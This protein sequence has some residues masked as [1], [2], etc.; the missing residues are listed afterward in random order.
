MS[1]IKPVRS[2]VIANIAE[3][4]R[5]TMIKGFSQSEFIAWDEASVSL[6]DMSLFWY[7]DDKVVLLPVQ[8][9]KLFLSDLND[10]LG[11]K[12]V[13][14][15]WPKKMSY[16]VC[17]DILNDKEL[18]QFLIKI[19][20][21][22]D[23]PEIVTW[24]ATKPFYSL[25][26]NLTQTGARFITPEIPKQTDYWTTLYFESKAGFREFVTKET[27]L[28]NIPEGFICGDKDIALD[29]IAYFSKNNRGFVLKANY[30][31]AGF[32]TMCY[33][34]DAIN[35][36]FEMLRKEIAY[37]MSFDNFWN[38]PPVIIEEH[39]TGVNDS[40]PR[41]LTIDFRINHDGQIN[42][43]GCG[44]MI[45]RRSCLYSGI[46]CG[47]GVIDR[48]T[49][50]Y[51]TKAGFYIGEHMAKSGYKGWF[52]VDFVQGSNGKI[53]LTEINA[54]RASPIHVFDIAAQ[55][56][57]ENWGHEWSLYANDHLY[58]Q[59]AHQPTYSTIRNAIA[60]F[61]KNLSSVQIIPTII[62]TA[63]TKKNPFIGYVVIAQNAT[64]AR[65]YAALLE[66]QIKQYVGM[67]N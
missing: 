53:F 32:S 60:D 16:S 34:A 33:P 10:A 64:A 21:S 49:E 59:G 36:G 50:N 61:T 17:N 30:G 45:M 51:M 42:K 27:H 18:Y 29:A 25:V 43:I 35:R 56:L 41:S 15:Y 62:S 5:R 66:K 54:R 31:T 3:Y 1:L 58:L 13:Q 23:N 55:L 28:L 47:K 14:V 52:D 22:S 37:R 44:E 6:T 63:I 57:G 20:K 8:P 4:N 39:I 26:E 46:H 65:K 9:N 19:I 2:I 48:D 40:F 38:N 11:Y 7:G 67:S 12:N 24:G